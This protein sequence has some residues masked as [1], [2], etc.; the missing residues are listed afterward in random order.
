MNRPFAVPET[1]AALIGIAV[2]VDQH[3]L[4]RRADE[5]IRPYILSGPAKP[6]TPTAG[7]AKTHARVADSLR[8]ADT[9]REEG[10]TLA[11]RG[12]LV[13]AVHRLAH[14]HAGAG[15]RR[16]RR[17]RRDGRKRIPSFTTLTEQVE[18][19]A[20]VSTPYQEELSHAGMHRINEQHRLFLSRIVRQPPLS[21]KKGAGS[22]LERGIPY[23]RTGS[24]STGRSTARPTWSLH[25][26]SPVTTVRNGK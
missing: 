20:R 9:W 23:C 3:R 10:E 4:A 26:G 15:E 16:A 24:D 14:R 6:G 21:I 7:L 8:A 12:R 25:S 17:G 1:A 2:L 13:S 11:G 22:P 18:V 5:E 19:A